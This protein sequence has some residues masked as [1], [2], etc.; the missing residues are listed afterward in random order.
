MTSG[1]SNGI[2]LRTTAFTT[3]KIAVFAPMPIVSAA[4]TVSVKPGLSLK[5]LSA[6]LR[7]CRRICMGD[8]A[9]TFAGSAFAGVRFDPYGFQAVALHPTRACREGFRG[10]A[11]GG[12]AAPLLVCR[13]PVD[14][15]NRNVQQPQIDRELT[16]VVAQMPQRLTRHLALRLRGENLATELEGTRGRRGRLR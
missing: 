11:P 5:S 14:R 8:R 4:I 1:S 2:G 16:P 15:W 13:R 10:S 3:E 7:S 12:S 6:C 9:P